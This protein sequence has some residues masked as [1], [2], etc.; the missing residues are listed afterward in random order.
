MRTWTAHDVRLRLER[1]LLGEGQLLD[2]ELLGTLVP[3]DSRL[4]VLVRSRYT[5]TEGHLQSVTF[6]LDELY[7]QVAATTLDRMVDEVLVGAVNFLDTD[8]IGIDA[9]GIRHW[10]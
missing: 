9:S 2:V 6:D 4:T 8:E 7:E 3:G 10:R 1:Y 5:G